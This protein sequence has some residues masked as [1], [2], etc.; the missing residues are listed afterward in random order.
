[1]DRLAAEDF[2]AYFRAVHGYGPFPW[3][4]RLTD[5]VLSEG[6]P[7]TIDLPTGT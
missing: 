3:Q 7:A 6:W 2:P 5:Q 4:R 1:M